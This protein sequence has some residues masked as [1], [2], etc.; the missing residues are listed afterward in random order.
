MVV[1]SLAKHSPKW[2]CQ[3]AHLV[4][5]SLEELH[6]TARRLGLKRRWFQDPPSLPAGRRPHYDLM[7]GRIPAAD[8][9]GV[10]AVDR[11]EFVRAL[12]RLRATL[13]ETGG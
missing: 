13:L 4:A 12:H 7:A 10:P 11:R 2:G 1:R 8:A 9:L 6:A 5:D 3:V